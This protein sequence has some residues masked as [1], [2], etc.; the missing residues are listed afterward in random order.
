M[1]DLQSSIMKPMSSSQTTVNASAADFL[2]AAV[3]ADH[4]QSPSHEEHLVLA[5]ASFNLS[6]RCDCRALFV[7]RG[8]DHL[9][10]L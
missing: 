6:V 7:A 10:V 8:T 3:L 4:T 1:S 9:G 2:P 5:Q